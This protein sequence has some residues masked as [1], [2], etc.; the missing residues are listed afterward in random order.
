MSRCLRIVV[1]ASEHHHSLD[2]TVDA[3]PSRHHVRRHGS[4]QRCRLHRPCKQ[5]YWACLSPTTSASLKLLTVTAI[6]SSYP[7]PNRVCCVF[8]VRMLSSVFVS[9][10]RPGSQPIQPLAHRRLF[11]TWYTQTLHS[12]SACHPV[13]EPTWFTEF[14]DSILAKQPG[15]ASSFFWIYF[16]GFPCSNL[17]KHGD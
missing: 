13:H 17:L 6:E 2:L 8:Q 16:I 7:R 4:S 12:S 14:S 9:S 3:K 10:L 15:P 1:E 5:V 11:F